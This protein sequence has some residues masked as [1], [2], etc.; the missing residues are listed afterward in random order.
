MNKKS[1]KFATR[2]IHAG[3]SRPEQDAHHSV[4]PP[5]YRS[6]IFEHE[7][8][9]LR[10]D[11]QGYSYTRTNNPNRAQLERVLADL[12]NGADAYAF[13][14]GMAAVHAVFQLLR[15][16]DHLLLAEDIYHGTRVL[17][18]EMAERWNIELS[19]VD[20]R[21]EV[22]IKQ[23]IQP[24]TRLVWL[25][26]P[27]NPLLQII[28][29]QQVAERVKEQQPKALVAADNTWP[30]PMNQR[31][32][33]LGADLVIHSTTKYLGGHSDLLGGAVVLS[34]VIT[35]AGFGEEVAAIQRKAGA[36]PSPED[37]WWL[38]RS[39]KTLPYRMKAHNEH[40]MQIARWLYSQPGVTQ[41]FYPGLPDHEGH[42]IAGKQMEGFG[43]MIS[44]TVD[45]G[46][47]EAL[48]VVNASQLITTASSL[49]GVESTWEHRLS[50]ESEESTT[51]PSLIRLSVGLEDPDDLITDIEQAL[52]N[53]MN[54]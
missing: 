47:Q 21:S 3:S 38:T 50:S 32:L 43:G 7:E 40:A 34:D 53:S 8:T 36:V 39:I 9:G 46:A 29:I 5:L 14:S 42:A 25:E 19:E 48:A 54:N 13:A 2:A 27:S 18:Q 16:G 11:E 44:F 24:N 33:E 35:E 15:S 30:T 17:A 12:E 45:G 49:G 51:D 26:T 20:M 1:Y 52:K 10:P 41:V 28:D 31:P 23:A 37:C 22:K 4:V 6:T